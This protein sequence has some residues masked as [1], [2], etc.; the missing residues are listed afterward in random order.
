MTVTTMSPTAGHL[1]GIDGM[2]R[3]ELE[4]LLELTDTF[5]G[6]AKKLPDLL[7]GFFG[8]VHC[9]H[10]DIFQLVGLKKNEQRLS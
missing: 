6:N 5:A 9:A 7:K 3:S 1:L 10:M 2:S 4:E 8:Y